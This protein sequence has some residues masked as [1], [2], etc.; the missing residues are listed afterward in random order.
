MPHAHSYIIKT[1]LGCAREAESLGGDYFAVH[2]SYGNAN[3]ANGKRASGE[4]LHNRAVRYMSGYR[5][6]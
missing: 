5:N 2:L 4:P 3:V 6:D 1:D